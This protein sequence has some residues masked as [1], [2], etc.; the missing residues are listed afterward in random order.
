MVAEIHLG[1]IYFTDVSGSKVRPILLLKFNS[2]NDLLYMPL[3][4]NPDIKGITITNI[5]LQDGYLPK[6][7]VVSTK[8]SV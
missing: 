8:K 7:S 4:S 2:F 5:D 6:T 1:K 3:T